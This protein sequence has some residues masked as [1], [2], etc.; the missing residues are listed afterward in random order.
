MLNIPE[1]VKSLFNR[2][3]IRKNIRITFPQSGRPDI[4]NDNIAAETLSFTESVCS[5]STFKYGLAEA[6]VIEFETVGIANMLGETIEAWVEIDAT[7]LPE[8]L[9]TARADLTFP[10][11]PVPLGRFVVTA[12]PR[13]HEAMAHRQVTASGKFNAYNATFSN[14]FLS[15]LRLGLINQPNPASWALTVNRERL[16]RYTG[17]TTDTDLEE[18]Q[19][20]TTNRDNPGSQYVKYSDVRL[21]GYSWGNT[22][23]QKLPLYITCR[24][25]SAS[26]NNNELAAKIT[27]L[28]AD[29]I[30]EDQARQT[31]AFLANAALGNFANIKGPEGETPT[32][33]ELATDIFTQLI[34]IF[35]RERKRGLFTQSE[36]SIVPNSG[37]ASTKFRSDTAR[38]GAD[39]SVNFAPV[40]IVAAVASGYTLTQSHQVMC[41]DGILI[42]RTSTDR[43][44]KN[45]G[46]WLM[47]ADTV[48]ITKYQAKD[49]T[50]TIATTDYIKSERNASGTH[51]T[52]F[53][54]AINQAQDMTLGLIEIL[55]GFMTR[56]RNGR[57]KFKKLNPTP[58]CTLNPEQ[59]EECWFDDYLVEPVGTIT[60]KLNNTDQIYT[61]GEGASSYAV[62]NVMFFERLPGT[63]VE[64]VN[65][66]LEQTLV[67]AL[68]DLVYLP[69]EIAA[70]N[71]PYVEAGD[72]IAVELADGNTMQ[73]YVLA[74]K[75]QGIQHLTD[76]ITA[77]GT[78]YQELIEVNIEET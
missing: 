66:A 59:Y 62:R 46:K 36:V 3:D 4:T 41:I 64:T 53:S 10:V 32:Q 37:G 68:N 43:T 56:G 29:L 28:P 25:F 65:T 50:V 23:A 21:K 77:E 5:Q 40:D 47:P 14:E 54:E 18:T 26:F 9:Q 30:S 44:N 20:A 52:D 11:Y 2:D 13:N 27:T 78:T 33:A 51:D 42:T 22:A 61:F 16:L 49:P 55:G 60:Y 45:L 63:T 12:C 6:S 24:Y 75:M 72:C 19:T 57:P 58:V 48:T 71:V 1:Q 38:S 8:E 15:A 31:A 70:V 17:I 74:R 76:S 73:T 35:E 67:P 7:T 69:A 39:N 34:Q